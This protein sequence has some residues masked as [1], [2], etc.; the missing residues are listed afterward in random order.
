MD[1]D[2]DDD[3][4][5]EVEEDDQAE[6]PATPSPKRLKAEAVEPRHD[7]LGLQ[8]MD[9]AEDDNAPAQL[10]NGQGEEDGDDFDPYANDDSSEVFRMLEESD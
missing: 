2:D 8:R 4:A 9:V 7:P 6:K 3:A 1:L 5:E 10:D